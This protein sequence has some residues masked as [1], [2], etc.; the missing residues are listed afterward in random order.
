MLCVADPDFPIY[1]FDKLIE[2]AELT[3]NLLRGSSFSPHVSAWQALNG[4]YSFTDTPIAPPGIKIVCFESPDQRKTWAPHGVDG[5]YIGPAFDHHR[6][7]RVYITSTKG[8]RTTGQLSWHPPAGYTLPGA[9][10]LDDLVSCL[11][12]LRVSCDNLT[13][14]HPDLAALPQANLPSASNLS[15]AI[16]TLASLLSPP[17]SLATHKMPAMETVGSERVSSHTRSQDTPQTALASQRV[18]PID[19]ARTLATASAQRVA[20]RPTPVATR[21]PRR[22]RRRGVLPEPDTPEPAISA[23]VS[24]NPEPLLPPSVWPWQEISGQEVRLPQSELRGHYA[25]LPIR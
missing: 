3:L 24:T 20:S 14:T 8:F 10:P 2:Q 16:D 19:P 9:S 21:T 4:A 17:E 7:Y 6:C 12:A 23:S 25:T 11:N 13:R 5:F 1:L 18:E 15:S 22:R